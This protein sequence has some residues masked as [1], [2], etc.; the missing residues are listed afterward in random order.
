MH[1]DN[2]V[3]SSASKR[4]IMFYGSYYNLGH[5]LSDLFKSDNVGGGSEGEPFVT[6]LMECLFL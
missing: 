1:G 5:A 2:S 3:K 6:N 4:K